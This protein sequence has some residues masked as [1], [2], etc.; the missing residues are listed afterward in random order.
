[1]LVGKTKE[2][3]SAPEAA[4]CKSPVLQAKCKEMEND[5]THAILISDVNITDFKRVLQFLYAGEFDSLGQDLSR[6]Q[7]VE[8]LA[9]IYILANVYEIPELKIYI[10]QRPDF[11]VDFEE[12][13]ETLFYVA[14]LIYDNVSESDDIYGTYFRGLVAESLTKLFF[15]GP[16]WR[17]STTE[18]FR[19]G[20]L[21]V[22]LC[23]AMGAAYEAHIGSLMNI[24]KDVE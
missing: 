22:D 20:R 8:K 7:V 11:Y 1:M 3:V 13:R 15:H 23:K 2:E 5:K 19:G 24:A 10:L 16:L 18:I 21:A 17:Y 14:R 12:D 9:G 4:L 6:A